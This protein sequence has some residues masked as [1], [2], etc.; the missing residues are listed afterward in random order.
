MT[1]GHISLLIMV[2]KAGALRRITNRLAAVGQ[3]AF[4]NYITHSVVCSLLFYGYAPYV[5]GRIDGPT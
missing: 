4:T 2:C 3:M 1:L 5:G